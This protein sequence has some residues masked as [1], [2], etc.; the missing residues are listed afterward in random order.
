MFM[1]GHGS[2]VLAAQEVQDEGV[3]EF[4]VDG[5][6]YFVYVLAQDPSFLKTE[7]LFGFGVAVGNQAQLSAHRVHD[8]HAHLVGKKVS[9]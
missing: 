1:V 8:Q 9:S 7:Q 5:R 6:H 2:L 3:M 4:G